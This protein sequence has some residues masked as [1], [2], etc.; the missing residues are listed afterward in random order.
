MLSSLVKAR[1]ELITSQFSVPRNVQPSCHM[2]HRGRDVP[3]PLEGFT[4]VPYRLSLNQ[5]T[6]RNMCACFTVTQ[7]GDTKRC[8]DINVQGETTFC[9][10]SGNGMHDF[11]LFL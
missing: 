8:K 10:S 9:F 5:M 2:L 11:A 7:K 3:F 1:E 6:V 4:D